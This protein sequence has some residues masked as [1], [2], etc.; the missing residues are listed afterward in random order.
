MSRYIDADLI[1]YE[2]IRYTL[3]NIEKAPEVALKENIDKIPTADV[4]E[5]KHGYW[6][7]DGLDIPNGVDWC[8]CSVCGGHR[9]NVPNDKTPYCPWCGAKM[10]EEVENG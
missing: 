4:I 10:D 6:A 1:E 7:E 2:K 8:H 3:L 9:V 5:V